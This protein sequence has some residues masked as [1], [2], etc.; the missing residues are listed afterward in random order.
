LAG[1]FELLPI[2][3]D[4]LSVASDFFFACM[5]TNIPAQFGAIFLQLCA[6]LAQLVAALP[7]I[8]A[9]YVPSISRIGGYRFAVAIVVMVWTV[10]TNVDHLRPSLVTIP[11]IMAMR[12]VRIRRRSRTVVSMRMAR[13]RRRA[14]RM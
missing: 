8:R 9:S 7:D 14:V 6:S 10:F 3:A 5:V 1:T 11:G 13:L 12:V 2:G 4:F